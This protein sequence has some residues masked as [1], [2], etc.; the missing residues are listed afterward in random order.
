M[1]AL[2]EQLLSINNCL[3]LHTALV[4][5]SKT[6]PVGIIRKAYEAGQRAF[7]ESRPQ[8]LRDKASKLP[9]DIEWHFI[10]H[11]QSN[12]IKLVVGLAHTIHSAD[13]EKL[14][15]DLNK[16]AA[17][18]QCTQRCLLQVRIAQEETKYGFAPD[19]LR[20]LAASGFLAQLP[21]LQIAGLMGMAT[22]TS[23]TAQIR[24]EFRTM[25]SLYTELQQT[26]FPADPAFCELSM[27]MSNDYA[28]AVEEGSTIVRVGSAIFSVKN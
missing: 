20:A 11:L 27:G 15:I 21:H 8:A 18:R 1:N 2:R 13:S 9:E 16:E 22:N 7:G 19:E 10:G 6:Q 3:P 25:K 14:L 12:K 24:R 28:I 4:A 26:C 5:V 17:R 23:D